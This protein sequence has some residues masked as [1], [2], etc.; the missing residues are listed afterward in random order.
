MCKLVIMIVSELVE[1]FHAD[2]FAIARGLFRA[3]EVERLRAHYMA[4]RES[5]PQPLD[6]AGEDLQ[7]ADPLKRYPR[8][9]H[10]HRWDAASLGYLRDARIVGCLKALFPGEPYGVQTMVYFKPPGA[11][12]Q[13]PHQDNFYL[14]VEPGTCA[15]AWMALDPC[16]EENGCMWMVPGSHRMPLLCTE[17]ADTRE[18]FTDVTVPV[19]PHL[20]RR[21]IVMEPGDVVFFHGSTIH[22]SAPNRSPDRFRR[23]VI[24][25][26]A[27]GDARSIHADYHPVVRL[28][29]APGSLARSAEGG[30]CGV[31]VERDGSRTI[32]LTDR[33]Q[34][35]PRLRE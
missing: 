17:R 34:M 35:S 11:R 13:A 9:I 6:Y 10:M 3:D 21:A 32:E 31:F 16:D 22:G 23:A 29:G 2:G 27:T 1:A 20:E 4:L 15:A 25:H 18:S 30:P 26:Y 33:P 24:A 28:D 8:M 5:G 14:R 19:P 7:A 12:G